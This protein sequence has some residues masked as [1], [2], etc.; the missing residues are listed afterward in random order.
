MRNG[1]VKIDIA[2]SCDLCGSLVNPYGMKRIVA[3]PKPYI[4]KRNGILARYTNHDVTTEP[5]LYFLF[6]RKGVIIYVGKATNIQFRLSQHLNEKLGLSYVETEKIHKI[7]VIVVDDSALRSFLEVLYIFNLNPQ[8]NNTPY[9]SKYYIS[10][11]DVSRGK[12]GSLND[13]DEKV[14][15]ELEEEKRKV[16]WMKEHAKGK[17]TI[18]GLFESGLPNSRSKGGST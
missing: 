7:S 6:D 16:E 17:P 10:S 3:K 15:M 5:G 9:Q 11:P 12:I 4:C 14:K 13:L 1:L 2:P 8:F 18:S